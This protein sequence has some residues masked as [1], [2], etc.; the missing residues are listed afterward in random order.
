MQEVPP[1]PYVEGDVVAGVLDLWKYL[2]EDGWLLWFFSVLVVVGSLVAARVVPIEPFLRKWIPFVMVVVTLLIV[3]RQRDSR[4]SIKWIGV[5]LS[6]R[7]AA[8]LL[9]VIGTPKVCRDHTIVMFYLMILMS[10]ALFV[11]MRMCG[12]S[13]ITCWSIH[14]HSKP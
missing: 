9:F 5:A 13:G 8:E 3:F 4:T 2:S 6:F 10:T 12:T 11:W 14:F 1:K 7:C